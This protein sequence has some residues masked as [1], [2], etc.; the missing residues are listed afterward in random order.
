MAASVH[1]NRAWPR[2]LHVGN[3]ANVA[4]GY[5][6]ILTTCG[7]SVKLI[8][9]DVT[10]LMSQPEWDDLALNPADFPN[11]N[12]FDLNTADFGDYR[13]PAWFLSETLKTSPIG[14]PSAV[15]RIITRY[16]PRPIK[17]ALEPLYY[18]LR[19]LRDIITAKD[20]T[21]GSAGRVKELLQV[22][23][24]LGP[25]WRIST[26]ALTTYCRHGDWVAAHAKECDVVFSYALAAIYTL[27]FTRKPRI[28]VDIG[29]MRDLPLGR[30][31]L[32]NLLWLA[33]RLSDHVLITN[34]DTRKLAE[35][36]GIRHY[37]FC[38]HPIDE[39][40]F[41]PGE[42]LRWR[43]HLQKQY[44]AETLLFAPARQNWRLKGSHKIF[45]G[46][47]Q[48]LACG[49]DAV[50]LV[51]GWGQEVSR[52]KV[53][54]RRLRVQNRVVWLAPVSEPV[55]ARYYRSVD[56]VLDQFEL[57]VF[58]LITPKAMACGAVVLT[59]YSDEHNAWCFPDPPPVVRCSTSEHIALAITELA[60]DPAK[61]R[62]I[63]LASR[64]WIAAHH[65]SAIVATRLR[66][67][68]ESAAQNFE[69]RRQ[70][71]S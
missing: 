39:T 21:H 55:L 50:L 17:R 59:S 44:S 52:S 33:Y 31:V 27:F 15:L 40:I 6:K 37:S 38:P 23:S 53:L 20:T 54:C 8:C 36:A 43:Q 71:V 14:F 45:E 13:R 41:S 7:A 49:T 61:R 70:D 16:L 51:P 62:A 12:R 46:F 18:H 32:G 25:R 34:P 3:V 64:E 5:A 35:K 1:L 22:A 4:Y 29:T 66:E 2:S 67:A 69:R 9:H 58:G 68:M 60:C 57:G 26:S 11:E 56:V 47:A 42:D 10:H 30:S 28:S 65:S 48:A 19:R 24:K 63:G